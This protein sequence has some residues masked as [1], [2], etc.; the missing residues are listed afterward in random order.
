MTITAQSQ[1]PIAIVLSCI[2]ARVPVE[3]IFDMTLGDVFVTRVAGNIANLDIIGSIEFACKIASAK[4]I[5]VLGHKE[6]GAIKAACD[7]LKLG[8]L[9]Q[10]IEKIKPAIEA[11][12]RRADYL[13]VSSNN[14]EF[15]NHVIQNNV[16]NTK[17]FLY[18]K[19]DV[20]RT[21][22]ENGKL[23]MIGAIYNIRTGVVEFE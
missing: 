10:L 19:S 7:N 18:E 13:D 2:D 11:E 5:I 1:H 6:C 17:S 22:L 9:T 21:L 12:K 4:L 16:E 8:Y 14:A 15:V 20:L 23:K 3:L